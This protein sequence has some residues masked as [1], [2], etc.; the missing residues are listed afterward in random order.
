[1]EP[2]SEMVGSNLAGRI[3][4][5]N[6]LVKGQ[7]G[8]EGFGVDRR[9]P[10]PNRVTSE[11]PVIQPQLPA[12]NMWSAPGRRGPP[13]NLRAVFLSEKAYPDSDPA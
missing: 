8:V 13:R 5:H 10:L 7:R 6:T 12:M 1:M 11:L 4:I 9:Q 2:R 3:A